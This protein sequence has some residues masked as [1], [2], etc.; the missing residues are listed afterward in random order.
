M[1][2]TVKGVAWLVAFALVG[3]VS[4][5]FVL[6]LPLND[7]K[8]LGPLVI[9]TVV[10][11]APEMGAL[12]AVAIGIGLLAASLRARV[13]SMSCCLGFRALFFGGLL[14]AIAAMIQRALG[15]GPAI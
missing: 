6:W 2:N 5:A 13:C 15:A 14:G 3:D 4:Y 11:T 9:L 7:P 8:Q 1:S 10:H 12:L